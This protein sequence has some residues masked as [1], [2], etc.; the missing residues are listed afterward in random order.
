MKN[1]KE[2]SIDDLALMVKKGFDHVDERFNKVKEDMDI[3]KSD[4]NDLK[5]GQKEIKQDL[6]FTARKFELKE[7]EVRVEKLEYKFAKMAK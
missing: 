6:T 1:K 4:V 7:L 2:M 3:L 5:K